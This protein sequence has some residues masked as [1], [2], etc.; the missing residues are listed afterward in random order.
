MTG[1]GLAGRARHI[2]E[3]PFR[4]P[5]AFR[6]D[7]V[8]RFPATTDACDSSSLEI[9]AFE[10]ASGFYF[11]RRIGGSRPGRRAG[12]SRAFPLS[13]TGAPTDPRPEGL[14]GLRHGFLALRVPIKGGDLPVADFRMFGCSRGGGSWA[15]A[16]SSVNSA[17][18]PSRRFIS[19]TM[20]SIGPPVLIAV[21][22]FCNSRSIRSDSLRQ[23]SRSGLR[24]IRRMRIPGH[25]SGL[26]RRALA[27]AAL[28]RR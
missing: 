20:A 15:L 8:G 16:S 12:R 6:R 26:P 24:S 14:G 28:L 19:E 9:A 5:A 2:R 21:S 17:F 10:G 7:R 11:P 27:N 1:Y 18:R 25:I 4:L 23:D 22:S 13:G 3:S